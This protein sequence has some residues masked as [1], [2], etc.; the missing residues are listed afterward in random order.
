MTDVEV[1]KLIDDLDVLA[2]YAIKHFKASKLDELNP[3]S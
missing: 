3:E 2:R 1:E